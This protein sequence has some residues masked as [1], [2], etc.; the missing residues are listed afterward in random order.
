MITRIATQADIPAIAQIYTDSWLRTY[1]GLLP[2]D[3]L[4]AM[5]VEISAAKWAK[6]LEADHQVVY[7]ATTEADEVCA[8]LALKLFTPDDRCALVD[9][10]HVEHQRTGQGIGKLLLRQAAEH[11][12]QHNIE[13]FVIEA[14]VGNDRA[15]A[16]YKRLGARVLRQFHDIVDG[17]HTESVELMWDDIT[18]LL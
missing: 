3:Y 15:I 2:D 17:M 10:L 11:A 8:L 7:V 4:D 18:V 13:R 14:V 12:Q 6:Y 1:R 5:S 9:S 16:V